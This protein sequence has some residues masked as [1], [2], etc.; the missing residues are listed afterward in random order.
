MHRISC[1][2]TRFIWEVFDDTSN[3]RRTM[4][5]VLSVIMAVDV[6]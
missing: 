2:E 6:G 1:G 4:G 5:E 3:G